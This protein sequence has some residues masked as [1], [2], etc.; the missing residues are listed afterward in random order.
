MGLL[1]TG[2]CGL[3]PAPADSRQGR[4]G[5]IA[6]RRYTHSAENTPPA[7]T[8]GGGGR[9]PGMLIFYRG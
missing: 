4:T 3:R 7:R 8:G 2:S 5:V 6:I 9:L 1:L